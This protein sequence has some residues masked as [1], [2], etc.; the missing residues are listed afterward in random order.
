MVAAYLL[1]NCFGEEKIIS[2]PEIVN[3]PFN[4]GLS[5]RFLSSFSFL[6]KKAFELIERVNMF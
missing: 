4:E 3:V 6:L 5:D 1:D 2:K